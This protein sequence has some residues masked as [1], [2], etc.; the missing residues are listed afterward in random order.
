MNNEFDRQY[1]RISKKH[2]GDFTAMEE[3]LMEALTSSL[4]KFPEDM[5]A[6][7][8]TYFFDDLKEDDVA[9]MLDLVDLHDEELDGDKTVLTMGDWTL[10]KN[11]VNS[12]AEDLDL[13]WVTYLM[14]FILDKGVL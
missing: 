9:R 1:R 3:D 12:Y 5:R 10:I 11:L 2:Q 8:V 6:E 14:Q 13:E 7:F 4:R